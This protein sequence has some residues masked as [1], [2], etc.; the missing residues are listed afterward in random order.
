M[1]KTLKW[2]IYITYMADETILHV[3]SMFTF[4]RKDDESCVPQHQML[5]YRKILQGYCSKVYLETDYITWD[6]LCKK[7][8]K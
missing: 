7:S 5:D 6:L 3:I 2:L 4:L 1:I 8:Y